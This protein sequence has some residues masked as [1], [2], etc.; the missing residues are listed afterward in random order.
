ML[1]L[2]AAGLGGD[3]SRAPAIGAAAPFPG[4]SVSVTDFGARG[5]SGQD[6]TAA[7]QAAID[8][9]ERGGGGSVLI[10][11]RYRCGN[12]VVSGENVRL[13]G[14]RG[15]LVDARLT[16][17]PEARNIE[18]AGLTVL[19][20]RGDPRTYLM[21]I[22]GR[23]CRFSNVALVK[24]P[25]AGGYQMYV[26]QPSAR[27]SFDGLR[28]RGSNGI[29]VAGSDHLFENFELESK[30]LKDAAGDDAFAIKA[31]EGTTQN[32]TI[33]N[34]VVR[35]YA[36][37]VSFGS[38]IGANGASG[39]LGAVRNVTVENVRGHHCSRLAFFKPDALP[40]D[41]RNG[42]VEGVRLRNL[43][44]D[45]R[46]GLYFRSGIQ[47]IAARGAVI[48]DVE[49]RG[50]RIIARAKDHGV[51]PTSAVDITLLDIGA[52]AQIEDVNLQLSF[53]DPDSGAPHGART[54]GYPVDHIV[55]I[56]KL[57]PNSGSMAGVV[58]DVEGDGASFGGIYVGPG[59]DGAV[60]LQRAV[61]RHVATN[62]PASH[63]GGGIWSDSRIS[64]G[65][66]QIQS[67]KLPRFGGHAFDKPHN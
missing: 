25:V 22:S 26:R 12:I 67:V 61:L 41:W 48:R 19:D 31:A 49:A 28:L 34:G 33:R 30:M 47:M 50:I 39:R 65:D 35:G 43:S 64:L 1:G 7:I 8:A 40:Y 17:S 63:G 3:W 59:L 32:I 16:I 52:P 62:P 18:V 10:P 13:Q 51:A 23:D 46:T 36:A 42:V 54:P 4:R 55:R 45:D 11:G 2:G 58:L 24:N 53:V 29:M 38:E 21:D 27:C 9:V 37:I 56:E 20:T 5:D 66:V 57:N 15:L 44:L 6:Q 60:S 14:Q